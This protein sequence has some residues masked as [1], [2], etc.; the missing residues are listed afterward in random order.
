LFDDPFAFAAFLLSLLAG[1]RS[2]D[3]VNSPH[4]NPS[5]QSDSTFVSFLEK[6][7]EQEIQLID[8]EIEPRQQYE[9]QPG[10]LLIEQSPGP[11]MAK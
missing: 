8:S 1:Y 6:H 10:L 5:C 2:V 4:H 7:L 3:R 11:N 9:T